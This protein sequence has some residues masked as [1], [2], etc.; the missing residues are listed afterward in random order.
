M[1]STTALVSVE[2]VTNPLAVP[3]ST[4]ITPQCRGVLPRLTALAMSYGRLLSR[5]Y[6]KAICEGG[7]HVPLDGTLPFCI[8]NFPPRCSEVRYS[9]LAR[10]R[11][12]YPVSALAP[13]SFR[14]GSTLVYVLYAANTTPSRSDTSGPGRRSSCSSAASRNLRDRCHNRV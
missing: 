13:A 8:Y 5:N 7:Q 1:L 12:L 9:Q 4:L 14:S 10:T 11:G 6:N 2:E 3:L